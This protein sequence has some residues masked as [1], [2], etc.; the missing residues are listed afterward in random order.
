MSLCEKILRMSSSVARQISVS[1]VLPLS[2][3]AE[4]AE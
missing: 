4:K 2:P 3:S 1:T